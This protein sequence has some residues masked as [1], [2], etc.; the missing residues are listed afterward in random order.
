MAGQAYFPLNI[1]ALPIWGL[2][3]LAGIF[4][5]IPLY[6]YQV[7]E[8]HRAHQSRKPGQIPPAFPVPFPPLGTLLPLIW[9]ARHTLNRYT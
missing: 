4:I 3:L 8:Y 7:L 2:L 5:W 6:L 1:L 9:D